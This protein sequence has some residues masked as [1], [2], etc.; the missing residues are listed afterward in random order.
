MM[1]GAFV[2]GIV[3][4]GLLM[5]PFAEESAK[6]KPKEALQVFND[7]IGPWRATGTPEGTPR[8]KQKGFWQEAHQWEWQ[9]K[10]ADVCLKVAIDKGKYFTKGELRFRPDKDQYEF[11]AVTPDGQTLT[12]TGGVKEHTLSLERQD[13]KTQETH[14]LVL[15]LIHA[16]R[17][18]YR[19]E[20]KP[21]DKTLFTKLYQ[22]GAVKEG[23]PFAGPGDASPECIVSGGL[24]TIKVAYK[25]QTYYVCCSGCRDAFKDDPEKFIKEY[26]DKKTTKGKK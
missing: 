16:N 9:F 18:L 24:G 19:Y 6:P 8:E 22:V 23:V 25:G 13:D 1:I 11:K 5:V 10:G 2:H 26:E 17:F 20:V 12:F 21:A 14:R 3:A 4:L 15:A 7:L